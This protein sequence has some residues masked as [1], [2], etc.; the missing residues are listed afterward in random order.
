MFTLKKL[1]PV[2]L[3]DKIEP[4]LPFWKRLGFQITAEVPH[5]M[6]LG[7]V[8][9]GRD[10]LEVMYQ[11]RTATKDDLPALADEPSAGL[12]FLEVSDLDALIAAL[13]DAPVVVP[14]RKTFYGTDEI[15]VRD[16]VGNLFLFAQTEAAE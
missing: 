5:G 8:I 11:T 1:T 10:G 12:F 3:V 14:R 7:F 6:D 2:L 9:L 16:P 4:V 15:G 13:G